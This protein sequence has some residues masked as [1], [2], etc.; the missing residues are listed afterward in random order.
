MSDLDE[1]AA[2][3]RAIGKAANGGPSPEL[4]ALLRPGITDNEI[5]EHFAKVLASGSAPRDFLMANAELVHPTTGLP[6]PF[7]FRFHIVRRPDAPGGAPPWR[8]VV[9]RTR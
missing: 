5:L 6:S 8:F 1:L 9:Q 4:I 7:G 2:W 3:L